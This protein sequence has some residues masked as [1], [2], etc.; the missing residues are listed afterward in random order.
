MEWGVGD[1]FTNIIFNLGDIKAWFVVSRI[2]KCNI[3]LMAMNIYLL[4][5][6][7]YIEVHKENIF[8]IINLQS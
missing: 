5:F 1:P 4:A 2:S 6:F 7:G 8:L 3:L